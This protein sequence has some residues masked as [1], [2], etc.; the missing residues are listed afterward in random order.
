MSYG[1]KLVEMPKLKNSNETNLGGFVFDLKNIGV[2]AH[3]GQI[4]ISV[5]AQFHYS[6]EEIIW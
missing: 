2:F 1:Q 3:F 6:S 4:L 5:S